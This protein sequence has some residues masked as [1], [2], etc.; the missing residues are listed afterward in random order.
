MSGAKCSLRFGAPSTAGGFDYRPQAAVFVMLTPCQMH[1]LAIG[2]GGQYLA[3][4]TGKLAEG[5]DL[6]RAD[7]GETLRT[8]TQLRV[9]P[10]R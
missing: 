1:E 9:R 2:A 7:K 3:I 4:T 10:E 6:G 5:L 8:D